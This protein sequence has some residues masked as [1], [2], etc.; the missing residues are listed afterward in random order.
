M[1]RF[2]QTVQRDTPF[3]KSDAAFGSTL[4]DEP[5]EGGARTSPSETR[6]KDKPLVLISSTTL[7]TLPIGDICVFRPWKAASRTMLKRPREQTA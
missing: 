2:T 5:E 6:T 1:T 3:E 4:R 7:V